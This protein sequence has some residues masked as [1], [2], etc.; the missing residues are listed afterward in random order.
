[1]AFADR[2]LTCRDCGA[3]FTFT[4][5]EQ[6][7]YATKGFANDP[8]RCP[9]C[10]ATHRSQRASGGFGDNRAA[11]RMERAPRQVYTT[12]CAACG[13]EAQVPFSPRGDKPVYCS[14]CFSKMRGGDTV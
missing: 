6:E 4:A 10:R 14:T 2:T 9:G 12:V 7:F 5:G 13:G 3:Q 8:T 1:M 11:G